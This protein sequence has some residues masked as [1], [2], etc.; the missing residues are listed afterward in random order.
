MKDR[1][2]LLPDLLAPGAAPAQGLS[3]RRDLLRLPAGASL[4][5]LVPLAG[6]E[7]DRD[8]RT[9]FTS[10]LSACAL[11]ATT[12][13]GPCTTQEGLARED[14]TAEIFASRSEYS[15]HGQPDTV[16]AND[17]IMAGITVAQRDRHGKWLVRKGEVRRVSFRLLTTPGV[18]PGAGRVPAAG[19][20]WGVWG[21][22]GS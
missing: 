9:P 12:T 11:V 4:F 6:C 21:E 20:A 19:G 5:S 3:S 1:Q 16:L 2:P 15:S 10:A 7:G 22:P 13:E 17:N 14:V 8:E 18:T